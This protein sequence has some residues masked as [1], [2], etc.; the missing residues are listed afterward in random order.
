MD[1][2]S[3]A[4]CLGHEQC[5]VGCLGLP[6]FSGVRELRTL[7]YAYS[8]HGVV[9]GGLLGH[10]LQNVPVLDNPAVVIEAEVLNLTPKTLM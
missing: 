2:G 5:R 6:D 3:Q 8:E 10:H 7:T 1:I 4:D 9:V